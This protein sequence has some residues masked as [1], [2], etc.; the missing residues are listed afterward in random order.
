MLD[1][2]NL[3]QEALAAKVTIQPEFKYVV[4]LGNVFHDPVDISV[5]V[6][7]GDYSRHFSIIGWHTKSG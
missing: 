6:S 5:I 7:S 2:T 3:I 1:F 4:R